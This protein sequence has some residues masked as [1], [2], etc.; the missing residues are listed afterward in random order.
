M[1][2]ILANCREGTFKGNQGDMLDIQGEPADEPCRKMASLVC[3]V[4]YPRGSAGPPPRGEGP[5]GG[6]ATPLGLLVRGVAPRYNIVL[7]LPMKME[8]FILPSS[9]PIA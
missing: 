7:G 6:N 1:N 9:R 3:E 5:S 2:L 4:R 8:L